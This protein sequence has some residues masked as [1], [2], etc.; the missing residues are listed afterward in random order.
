M[1]T[2]LITKKDYTL[3]KG[4]YNTQMP[5]LVSQGFRPLTTRDIMQYRLQALQSK[6]KYEI[7]FWLND[8]WDS[9]TGLACYNGNLIVDPNSQEL[10]NVNQNI[11]HYLPLTQ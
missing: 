1:E 6:D 4:S 10:L 9:V 5:L 2:I 3:F 7:D 8:Y 11:R